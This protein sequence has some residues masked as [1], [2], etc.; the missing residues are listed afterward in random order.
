MTELKIANNPLWY[1]VECG[2]EYKTPEET[3]ECMIADLG[4][5]EEAKT[6]E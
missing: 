6:D 2:T 1:C 5:A 4:D 3:E